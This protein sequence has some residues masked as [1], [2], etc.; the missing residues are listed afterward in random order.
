MKN[1]DMDIIIKIIITTNFNDWVCVGLEL[2]YAARHPIIFIFHKLL[3]NKRRKMIQHI[4][5]HTHTSN[6]LTILKK[7]KKKK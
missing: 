2:V 7:E 4:H 3:N 5:T 1:M 6:L